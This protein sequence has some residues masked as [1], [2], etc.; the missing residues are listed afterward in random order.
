MS[1]FL[2]TLQFGNSSIKMDTETHTCMTTYG[3][4]PNN[5]GR[6][7]LTHLPI[8]G[9]ANAMKN[10]IDEDDQLKMKSLSTDMIVGRSSRKSTYTT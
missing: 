6:Y 8:F 2:P 10:E 1:N 4:S 3:S 5:G 9:D 7:R